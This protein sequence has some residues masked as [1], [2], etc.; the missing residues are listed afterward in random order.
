[1]KHKSNT[2][3]ENSMYRNMTP[4]K[5][6]KRNFKKETQALFYSKKT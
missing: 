6:M 5:K 1:M 2:V 4:L 3:H